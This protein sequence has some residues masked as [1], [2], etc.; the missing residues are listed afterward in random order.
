ME[1]FWPGHGLEKAATA[2]LFGYI[3]FDPATIL[4]SQQ[5]ISLLLSLAGLAMA[6]S[7]DATVAVFWAGC[8]GALMFLLLFASVM[9]LQYPALH[10]PSMRTVRELITN[11]SPGRRYL[12]LS[13]ASHLL[14]AITNFAG[15]TLLASFVIAHTQG[16]L[17][18]RMGLAL[19]RGFVAASTWSPFFM[20]MA[21]VVSIMPTLRWLDVAL[22]GGILAVLLILFGYLCDTLTRDRSDAAPPAT[23][24]AQGS[25]KALARLGGLSLVLVGAVA[26]VNEVSG[27]PI[28]VTIALVVTV[29]SFLWL[30]GIVRSPSPADDEDVGLRHYAGSLEQNVGS[31]RGMAM[32]FVGANIFG[33]GVSRIIDGQLLVDAASHIGVS[34]PWWIPVLMCS[35]ALSSVLGLHAIVLIV[36]IGHTLPPAVLG[37][38][39]PTLALIML[40]SWGIGGVLSPFSTLTLYMAHVL[41]RP[42]WA[43]AWRDNGAY[44]AGCVVISCLVI[45]AYHYLSG[46]VP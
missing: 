44:A 34:G 4:R 9:Q 18:R 21:V 2:F 11:L 7:D 1:V 32:L 29:F 16:S 17:Q 23:P 39:Q 35:I 3:L 45:V 43:L 46:G 40:A 12:W 37:L 19:A 13:L 31:L 36:V 10:S 25:G 26:V 41:K 22:P 8:R 27:L 15:F 14:S 5:L 24:R 38:S 28:A 20:A 6:A 33:Q 42:Y 30:F